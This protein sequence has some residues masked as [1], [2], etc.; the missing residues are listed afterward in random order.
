VVVQGT[1]VGGAATTAR[2]P[3]PPRTLLD[4][5][6]CVP[7]PKPS[8]TS[9]VVPRLPARPLE[10]AAYALP[11]KGEVLLGS[12]SD[13]APE[14]AP[15]LPGPVWI[16]TAA[17]DAPVTVVKLAGQTVRLRERDPHWL[18]VETVAEADKPADALLAVLGPLTVEL[19]AELGEVLA[20]GT[21][22]GR[23]VDGGL[24]FAVR[25]LR[26]GE[27]IE[28]GLAKWGAQHQVWVDPRNVLPSTGETR[29]PPSAPSAQSTSL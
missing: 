2:T 12:W 5:G 26:P 20:P 28:H 4:D 29:E 24:G 25:R 22:L 21:R 27:N 10:Y 15:D 14:L 9:D 18:V 13:L 8:D 1:A 16:I 19:N 11:T 7:L 3:C 17:L 23:A 6:A